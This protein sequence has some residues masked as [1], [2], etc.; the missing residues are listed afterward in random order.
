[1]VIKVRS[2]AFMRKYTAHLQNDGE[3]SIAPNSTVEDVLLH[4]KVPREAKKILLVN[5][6]P[7]HLDLVLQPGDLLVFYPLL[8]GG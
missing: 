3:L 2:Y 4:L 5:G 1:M 6:R 7:A 8:E